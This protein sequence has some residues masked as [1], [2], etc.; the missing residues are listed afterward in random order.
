MKHIQDT[1]YKKT[2]KPFVAWFFILMIGSIAIPIPLHELG[3]SDNVITKLTLIIMVGSVDLL[4]YMIYKWEYVYWIN[5][6]LSGQFEV[7]L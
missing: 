2:Y 5:G 1:D 7:L 3:I 6:G 4:M